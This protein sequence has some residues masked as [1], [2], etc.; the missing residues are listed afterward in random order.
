M[1]RYIVTEVESYN[2]DD[3]KEAKNRNWR[4]DK[5]LGQWRIRKGL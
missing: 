4:L 5:L 2:V 1:K 3:H